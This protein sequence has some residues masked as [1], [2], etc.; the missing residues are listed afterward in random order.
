MILQFNYLWPVRI[1]YLKLGP[2]GPSVWIKLIKTAA[3][4]GVNFSCKIYMT[5]KKFSLGATPCIK[6]DMA[7]MTHYMLDDRRSAKYMRAFIFSEPRIDRDKFGNYQTAQPYWIAQ[8]CQWVTF[9]TARPPALLLKIVEQARDQDSIFFMVATPPYKKRTNFKPEQELVSYAAW[10]TMATIT[11]QVPPEG[12]KDMDGM[13]KSLKGDFGAALGMCCA[14]DIEGVLNFKF[15]DRLANLECNHRE[16]VQAEL[17]AKCPND[18]PQ[19]QMLM[20]AWEK[21]VTPIRAYL[22]N[23]SK[24]VQYNRKVQSRVVTLI[25]SA[26]A[27]AL[28]EAAPPE[29]DDV[30]AG[31]LPASA[32]KALKSAA[33][34]VVATKGK[35]A[36]KPVGVPVEAAP[37][38]VP[39]QKNNKRD[40]SGLDSGVI[41][42]GKRERKKKKE[43]DEDESGEDGK[44]EKAETEKKPK[45]EKMAGQGRVRRKS[46]GGYNTKAKK[47]EVAL[48]N[49]KAQIDNPNTG[50]NK[51]L[52]PSVGPSKLPSCAQQLGQSQSQPMHASVDTTMIDF[53]KEQLKLKEAEIKELKEQLQEARAHQFTCYKQGVREA[54][55]LAT[56]SPVKKT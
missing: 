11:D 10:N 54:K 27:E 51:D 49:L 1:T 36:P 56:E 25:P 22:N 2:I 26:N 21:K 35:A 34:A 30:E 3:H 37:K 15:Q 7:T 8:P 32:S 29:A 19:Q 18:Q 23:P 40:R 48:E 28:P 31:K 16:R 6:P 52:S 24:I 46:P 42:E 44:P 45:P 13:I 4:N 20:A 43:N 5:F 39:K 41:L 50:I 47:L 33:K 12:L 38:D 14:D 17:Q 55:G 53:Y 9:K